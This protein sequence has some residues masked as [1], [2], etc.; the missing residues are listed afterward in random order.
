MCNNDINER[1]E[2]YEIRRITKFAMEQSKI[3]KMAFN[4]NEKLKSSKYMLVSACKMKTHG[5][6][7]N[8]DDDDMEN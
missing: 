7:V 3:T 2:M 5:V 6:C 1:A 8:N 4:K